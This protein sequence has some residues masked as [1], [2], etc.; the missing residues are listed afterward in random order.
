VID[1]P[2]SA[3]ARRYLAGSLPAVYL[4]DRQPHLSPDPFDVPEPF[5][6]RWLG[7]LEQVLDPAVTLID[8]FAWHLDAGLCPD[9]LVGVLLCW[10]GLEVAAELDPSVRRSLLRRAMAL[11]RRRGT[12]A[13]LSE[14]LGHVFGGPAQRVR[15]RIG[16]THNGGVTHGDDPAERPRAAEPFVEVHCSVA[17]TPEQEDTLRRLMDYACPAHAGWALRI[18]DAPAR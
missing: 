18:G 1:A 6:V 8:N 5:V 11:G 10:L 13:G 9:D 14:L 16:V 17:L 15:L 7:G 2:V 3:S 4:E 12:F